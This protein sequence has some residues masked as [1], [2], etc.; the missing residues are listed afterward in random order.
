MD[1]YIVLIFFLILF[2][3]AIF[4]GMPIGF[5]MALIGFA[6]ASYFMTIGAGLSTLRTVPYTTGSKYEMSVIP[7][8]VLMG[9]IAFR[10]GLSRDLYEGIHKI[11]ANVRGSLAMATIGGCAGFAAICGSSLATSA[12]MGSVALPEMKK[13]KYN[14]KLATGSVAA[15]GTIGI[16]IPPSIGLVIYGTITDTSIGKLL[17]AGFMPG[18]LLT[19]LF[20]LT[21]FIIIRIKPNWGGR[22]TPSVSIKDRGSRS[23]GLG[24]IFV[25]FLI[26]IGG[27]YS[28][29][30]TPTEAS[31]IGAFGAFIMMLI[32]GQA[33]RHNLMQCFFHT[34]RT[35]GLIF[36]IM[37]GAFIFNYFMAVSNMP[38]ELAGFVGGLP[39]PR[40]GILITILFFFML[41][42]CIMDA[43][44]MLI[45]TVPVFLPLLVHLGYDPIWFGVVVTLIGEIG[46]IT[47]PI[48]L[49]VFVI[50]GVAPD[51]P[52][53]D[54]F[55]G[56]IPFAVTA[57]FCL[58]LLIAFPQIALFLPNTMS[59]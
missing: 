44:A 7:L 53:Y 45:L 13:L 20:M 46:L 49:N 18:L 11:L 21:I 38:I 25:L 48:G 14:P 37:I 35:V 57:L 59:R 24:M 8:F 39:I 29:I 50:R 28:G 6:G 10:A 54:I 23:K 56:I 4:L 16:M 31:G 17:L 41:L 55:Q 52:M 2:F 26:V 32:K 36:C 30:F 3:T 27:I 1:P 12:T 43:M 22:M 40:L 42:G 58:V 5:A 47:P 9:E 33:N 51:V 19:V 34:G 15:G